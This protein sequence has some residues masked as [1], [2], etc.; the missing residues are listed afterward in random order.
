MQLGALL[1]THATGELLVDPDSVRSWARRAEEEGFAGLWA[2]SHPVKPPIYNTGFIDPLV[3]LSHAAAVTDEI[4]LGTSILLLPL[5]NTSEV[6]SSVLSLQHLSGRR[7][8]LGVGAGNNPHEFDVAGIPM[9]ERGPRLTEGIE[10]LQA[11]FD[12]EASYDGRFHSFEGIRI[13]PTADDPPRLLSGGS[14]NVED[15]EYHI[16]E[17]IL[18][19]VVTVGGWIAP[20]SPLEKVEHDWNHIK[21]YARANGVDPDHIDRLE[22]QYFHI[23]DDDDP[24]AVETEQ[25]EVFDEYYGSRGYDHAANSCLVGTIEEI[26][27]RLKGYERLGFDEVILGPAAHDDQ[28]LSQQMDLVSDHL[29]PMF[30]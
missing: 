8:S 11:L 28:D 24:D 7:F 10:V 13:D 1:P 15:G 23:V 6:A 19:R 4:P 21:E 16:P 14:S 3:V 9:E 5:R 20:P 22:L 29:L 25:R 17:P 18:E 2:L 12:G 30:D 27:E 26:K